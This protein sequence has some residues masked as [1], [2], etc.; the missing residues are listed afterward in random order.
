MQHG[1]H[2]IVALGTGMTAEWNKRRF[3]NCIVLSR[4]LIETVGAWFRVLDDIHELLPTENIRQIHSSL[5]VAMFGHRNLPSGETSLPRAI[6][7]LTGIDR[8]DRA[9][10]GTRKAYDDICEFVHPNCDGYMLFGEPDFATGD[11]ELGEHLLSKGIGTRTIATLGA[12]YLGVAD[13]FMEKY[14]SLFKKPVEALDR[15]FGNELD[16]W[17]GEVAD[18]WRGKR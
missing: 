5:M 8:L 3:L 18:T 16:S 4:S 14:D 15:K 17:P 1:L 2:R 6:N 10:P 13:N 7:A 12:S 11:T 9:Y